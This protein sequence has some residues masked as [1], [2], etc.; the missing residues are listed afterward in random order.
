MKKVWERSRDSALN[1][2]VIYIYIF[3]PR[4]THLFVRPFI[5]GLYNNFI[6]NDRRGS[7]AGIYMQ[8]VVVEFEKHCVSTQS[9]HLVGPLKGI[10]ATKTPHHR[11]YCFG[12]DS[13]VRQ[14]RQQRLELLSARP[15]PRGRRNLPWHQSCGAW[16][17][18]LRPQSR[19]FRFVSVSSCQRVDH[20]GL[21]SG[22][23]L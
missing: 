11:S 14:Q 23:L 18:R 5:L 3:H 7:T 13:P 4:S 19:G 10:E 9:H 22:V 12:G 16:N 1:W 8:L 20:P 2:T 6:Y 21:F 17:N 15:M